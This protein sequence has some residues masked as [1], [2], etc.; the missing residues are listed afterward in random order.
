MSHKNTFHFQLKSLTFLLML[1]GIALYL[2]INLYTDFQTVPLDTYSLFGAPYASEIYDGKFWGI[3]TNSLLHSNFWHLLG[4]LCF[5]F[6]LGS[7]IEQE[8]GTLFLLLFGL[9]VSVLSS[10][11]QLAMAGDPGIGFTGTNFGLAAY[12]LLRKEF[13][14]TTVEKG[15]F[16]VICLGT[17]FIGLLNHFYAWSPIGVSALAS[18]FLIGAVWAVLE[19]K[20]WLKLSTLFLFMAIAV[21]SLMYNPFSSEW[22]TLQGFEAFQKGKYQL[23]KYHYSKAL[24]ISKKNVVAKENLL[25]VNIAILQG[26]AYRA[27]QSNNYSLA[28]KH[29]LKI[30]KLDPQN[31]W[32]KQNL[33]TLP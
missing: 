28:R 9:I 33:Q 31:K 3:L 19:E 4:N 21:G 32:A 25:K 7:L 1:V 22:Q 26:E 17:I 13:H 12:Y 20:K 18:G 24:E 6:Y 16:Y 15:M 10:T 5:L 27:H 8:K 23:A 2:A 14:K 29:Y 11:C 30:L